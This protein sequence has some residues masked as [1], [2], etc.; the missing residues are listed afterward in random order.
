M[1]MS[2]LLT[3]IKN[4]SFGGIPAAQRPCDFYLW[5]AIL[6]ENPHLFRIIELGTWMGGFSFYLAAQANIRGMEFCTY[7]SIE[8]FDP[9]KRPQGFLKKDIFANIEE[10]GELISSAPCALFCDNG[11]KPREV[12]TFAPYLTSDS[13]LI[14]HD[15]MTEFM[16]TDIPD[17]MEELYTD[18]SE[19]L[20]SMSRVLRKKVFH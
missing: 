20:N 14:V 1:V 7:D 18:F 17:Y 5:E 13:I 11:N 3:D 4:G 9:D 12:K 6:N 15:W 2:D 16:D 8:H 10:I 19:S